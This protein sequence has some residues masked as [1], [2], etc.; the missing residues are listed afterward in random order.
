VLAGVLPLLIVP[1]LLGGRKASSLP[2]SHSAGPLSTDPDVEVA[3]LDTAVTLAGRIGA[4]RLEI[5]RRDRGM[6]AP[7]PFQ[8]THRYDVY[9][10]SLADGEAAVWNRLHGDST[11]RSIR[12]AERQGTAVELGQSEADWAAMSELQDETSRRHGTPPPPRRFF[13]S[14]CFGL[15]SQ[16]LARLYLARS[17]E[18]RIL[19][20]IVVWRGPQEWI[21]AFGATRPEADAYRPSHALLWW[22]I[23]DAIRQGCVTFDFGRAAPEQ[24]GLVEFKRRWG[25]EPEPLAYDYWPEPGGLQAADRATGPLAVAARAWRHL[26]LRVARAG[27]ALYR[28]LG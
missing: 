25:A 4:R 17:S 13:T 8:R 16:N 6:T 28:Y 27:S 26:P 10:I 1:G 5:K 18:G 7:A 19:G 21:Y 12:R 14:T 3:L 22:A 15:A 23:R 20:G 24:T 11:R 2:F 9:R